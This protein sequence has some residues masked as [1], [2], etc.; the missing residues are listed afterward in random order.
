M[1][2]NMSFWVI[3]RGWAKSIF[4]WFWWFLVQNPCFLG[5]KSWQIRGLF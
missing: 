5:W 2:S 1:A 3:Y 4:F